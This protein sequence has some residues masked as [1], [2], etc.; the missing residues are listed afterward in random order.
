MK[1]LLSILTLLVVTVTGAWAQ[2][3]TLPANATPT[4]SLNILTGDAKVTAAFTGTNNGKKY[5]T[6]DMGTTIRTN[7]VKN[8]AANWAAA[9]ANDGG[10]SVSSITF[11]DDVSDAEKYGFKTSSLNSWGINSNRY[12]GIRVVNCVEAAVSTKSNSTKDNKT[13]QI[14]VYIKNGDAWNYVET[15]G[16]DKYNKDKT[17]VLTTSALDPSEEYI[18]LLTSGSTSNSL[19]YEIRFAAPAGPT[20]TT[21]TI[22]DANYVIGSTATE[23]SVTATASAGDL[24]YQWYSNTVKSTTE[25]TPTKISGET[26]ATYTPNTTSPGTTYYFCKVTDS[27]GSVYS[28][29]AEIVVAAASAPTITVTGAPAE[30]VKVGTAITLTADVTGVPTPTIKWFSNTTKSTSGGTVIEGATE[31]TYSP[32]T[33]TAGTYYYYAQA[34]NTEGDA[35]SE[36]QTIV[37]QE[38]VKKPTITPG[39]KHFTS[40]VTMTASSETAGATYKYS[41]DGGT[42]WAD[43]PNEGVAF[44]ETKTVQVKATKSGY[45]DSD[46]ATATYTFYTP[47]PLATISEA[48]TWD[49]ANLTGGVQYSG[50]DLNTEF[51][52][53]DIDGVSVASEKTFNTGALAFMGEYPLRSGQKASQN[54]TLH[55]KTSVS[56]AITV[57]FSDTGSSGS[58]PPK[59]YLNVNGVNSEYYTQRTGKGN[60]KQE[61]KVVAVPAGDVYITGMGEDGTTPR[62]IMVYKVAFTPDVPVVVTSAEWASTTT[63]NYAVEFGEGAKAYIATSSEGDKI[64][65]TQITDAPAKTAVIVNAPTGTYKLIKKTTAKSDVTGNL[66]KS[67][68]AND[69]TAAVGDYALG[70][71]LDG[72]NTVVGFGR[73][74]AAGVA[75]MTD[76]KA[77]IPASLLAN[78]VDFLPFVIGDEESET[79][80]INSIENGESRIENYDYFN[81]SGQRVGKDYKGI[82]IVNGK[83]VIRK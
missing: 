55:F 45:V 61:D 23:L 76:D 30:P 27:N 58:N 9:S 78:A 46:V 1:K 31:E 13:L 22:A 19:A 47:T 6:Y 2:D 72:S 79:T 51:V 42:N 17:Y 67:K 26:N 69:A 57:T 20:I 8:K 7:V 83:K 41:I 53:V 21:Q 43:L 33:E 64:K 50:D 52:Y 75:N 16:A 28:D 10:S 11:A 29:I 35:L 5:L 15:I 77:F 25:G 36:V 82:V 73:L 34:V 49:F 4:G 12:C 63:P 59:R 40:S 32:S 18:I 80:S 71:W 3:P 68:T 44:T 70:T 56:G 66:L 39:S 38:Q 37:V 24:S 54:G 62:A 14:Q 74:N 48:T 65:L 81:L 60:D